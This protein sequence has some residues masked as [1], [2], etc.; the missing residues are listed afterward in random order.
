MLQQDLGIIG[1]KEE[2]EDVPPSEIIDL[3]KEEHVA[4]KKSSSS[5]SKPT[6]AAASKP[7]AKAS[8]VPQAKKRKATEPEKSHQEA[9]PG[10]RIKRKPGRQDLS[11]VDRSLHV[12]ECRYCTDVFASISNR[13]SHVQGRHTHRFKCAHCKQKYMRKKGRNEKHVAECAANPASKNYSPDALVYQ[14]EAT[15]SD[16]VTEFEDDSDAAVVLTDDE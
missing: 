9:P 7:S 14:D 4:A 13:T 11:E 3:E 10:K 1:I 5:K 16:S 12:F 8:D 6:A 2:K 15:S